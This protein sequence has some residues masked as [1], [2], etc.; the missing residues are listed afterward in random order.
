[1]TD[2][3]IIYSDA[4]RIPLQAKS[5]WYLTLLMILLALG[6]CA[7]AP[8]QQASGPLVFPPPP[9]APRFV[10]ERTIH[11]TGAVA[12]EDEESSLK[13]LLTGVTQSTGSSFAKPFDVAVHQGRVFVT[14]TVARTV[15]G[16]DFVEQKAIDWLI[17]NGKV[18][19][20]KVSFKDY[21]NA[22]AS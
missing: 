10:F 1:M 14:D 16:M 18:K 3:N 21:M 17:E 15:H 5:P 13:A 22:P 19:A 4:R 9:D 2:M 8:V 7:P 6:G 20:K 12:P 11:G